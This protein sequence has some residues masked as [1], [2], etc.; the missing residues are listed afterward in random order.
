MNIKVIFRRIIFI[1]VIIAVICCIFYQTKNTVDDSVVGTY[2]T[3]G[4][5]AIYYVLEEDGVYCKYEQ[6]SVLDKGHYKFKENQ[7][8]LD[9]G[10]KLTIENKKLYENE[11]TVYEKF[12]NTPTYINV[13]NSDIDDE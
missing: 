9:N 10:K 3:Q 2:K 6:F 5:K 11:N 7:I 4:I 13:K 12:S 8:K 1:V